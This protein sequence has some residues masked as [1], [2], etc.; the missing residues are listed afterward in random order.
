M[1]L[2]QILNYQKIIDLRFDG[3]Y[4]EQPIPDIIN[5][6]W[7]TILPAPPANNSKQTI[8]E[9]KTISSL[10]KNRSKEEE[11][12]VYIID[13]DTDSLFKKILDK[14]DI[15]YPKKEIEDIY[16]LIR[17]LLLNTK[18]LWNRP[19]PYQLAKLYGIPIDYINTDTHHT[20][21]YPSG[22]TVYSSLA[23]NI[24]KDL[25]PQ[26]NTSQLDEAVANTA[27]AR[28]LQGVH[29]PSDNQASIIF[30]KFVFDKLNTKIKK[31]YYNE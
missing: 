24:I 29:Y 11:E 12:L 7:K 21:A 1:N 23:A 17:P 4:I 8:K 27:K 31:D 10:T 13:Q 19:R 3:I 5:F 14:Y 18:S 9:L 6:Q 25:Y 22:H 15:E 16:R 2:Y 30:T 26:I 28:I 20:A